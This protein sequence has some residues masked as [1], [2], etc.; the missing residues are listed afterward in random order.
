[1]VAFLTR[2]MVV[3]RARFKSR[4]RLET[5][6]LVLRQQLLVQYG[7]SFGGAGGP[8]RWY[9]GGTENASIFANCSWIYPKLLRCFAP[10]QPLNVNRSPYLP[11]Q[12]HAFHPS[13]FNPP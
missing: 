6:N 2:L 4:A 10:A 3:L 8:L 11:V 12:F 13:A 5:E 9:P 7:S 1:M